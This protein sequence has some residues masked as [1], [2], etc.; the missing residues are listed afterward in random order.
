VL[1]ASL[2]GRWRGLCHP[3]ELGLALRKLV[4]LDSGD[5]M[6]EVAFVLCGIPIQ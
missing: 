2:R 3:G 6:T 5:G 1:Q 4:L